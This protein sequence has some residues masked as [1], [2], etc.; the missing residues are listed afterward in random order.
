[1]EQAEAQNYTISGEVIYSKVVAQGEGERGHWERSEIV[2]ECRRANGNTY[3]RVFGQ[4]GNGETKYSVGQ[5]GRFTFSHIKKEYTGASGNT[6][7]YYEDRIVGFEPMSY[8]N[9]RITDYEVTNEKPD[10]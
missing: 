1:M 4:F 2:L 10:I 8:K 7:K 9:A 3:C 6:R 5:V